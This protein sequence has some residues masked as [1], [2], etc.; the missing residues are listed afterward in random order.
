MSG[1]ALARSLSS[2]ANLSVLLIP[3]CNVHALM[4][5]VSKVIISPHAV[6]PNGA[7]LCAPGSALACS[8]ARERSVPIVALAG[9]HRLSANWDTV[10]SG[11]G[12]GG[13]VAAS[14]DQ[15]TA[16]AGAGA[17]LDLI[18]PRE[19]ARLRE[20]TK[21]RLQGLDYVNQ[22]DLIITNTGE[23]PAAFVYRLIKEN[24]RVDV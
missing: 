12:G 15:A 18:M 7:L 8:I 6:L 21:V 9:L 11:G 13:D 14:A 23:H 20:E 4:P 3:D 24:Y 1:H 10:G 2:S 19:Y 5:R 16:K 22:P 17:M